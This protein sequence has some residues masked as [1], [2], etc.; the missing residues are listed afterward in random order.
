M[1]LI[2]LY[3][4][5]FS[6]QTYFRSLYCS[7]Y[8]LFDLGFGFLYSK[9]QQ[10]TGCLEKVPTLASSL[11][12]DAATQL[13]NYGQ[14]QMFSPGSLISFVSILY[15]NNILVYEF[16]SALPQRKSVAMRLKQYS[17]AVCNEI[18]LWCAIRCFFK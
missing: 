10:E 3:T 16:T 14:V 2:N 8:C 6:Y 17:K 18:V 13:S 9:R 1:Q 5:E 12:L 15:L 4:F 11:C 7:L